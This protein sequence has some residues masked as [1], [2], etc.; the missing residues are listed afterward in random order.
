MA[1]SVPLEALVQSCILKN[2]RPEDFD[3]PVG[4]THFDVADGEHSVLQ[5]FEAAAQSGSR[6][7]VPFV[8]LQLARRLQRSFPAL[9][10]GLVFSPER[11]EF[12][13]VCAVM[14]DT[15]LNN[16]H[17]LTTWADLPNRAS[18]LAQ[19]FG[20]KLFVRP[21]A[22]TKAFTGFTVA[23]KNLRS[24][25]HALSQTEHTPADEL[26]VVAPAQSLPAVEWRFWV[27][28]G[29]LVTSAPYRW[30][31][32]SPGTKD[33]TTPSAEIEDFARVAASRAE[34]LDS[35]LVLDVVRSEKG[36]RVV[37]LNPLSTSGFYPG[38]DLEA[39][40]AAL[41]DVLV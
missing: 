17:F 31:D 13:R 14:G 35:A 5:E 40:L 21:N 8:S 29:Q 9:C 4:T 37:E 38:M 6:R 1:R 22:A 26:C 2:T 3:F 36:P 24:E 15:L 16:R 28:D 25:H 34:L 32:A 10:C 33:E 7:V 39:L 30:D 27:V 12:H 19:A 23:A 11:L 20:P 41:D 18:D